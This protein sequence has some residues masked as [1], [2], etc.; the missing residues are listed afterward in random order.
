MTIM[1]R[2]RGKT[3]AHIDCSVIT[4]CFP[5]PHLHPGDLLSRYDRFLGLTLSLGEIFLLFVKA[6]ALRDIKWDRSLSFYCTSTPSIYHT[7]SDMSSHP[8]NLDLDPL[9]NP[10]PFTSSM[11][12]EHYNVV[13]K[14]D[15]SDRVSATTD[16]VGPSLVSEAKIGCTSRAPSDLDVPPV[17][18][19]IPGDAD[20][21]LPVDYAFVW[22]YII[23]HTNAIFTK[24][25]GGLADTIG[26]LVDIS[27]LTAYWEMI[28]SYFALIGD[29]MA[30]LDN[31]KMPG[32][33]TR[34]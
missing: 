30:L 9:I 1:L 24:A 27:S 31:L 4:R 10:K 5:S 18:N 6:L 28:R 20:M 17:E 7:M 2:T 34:V 19:G 26:N 29:R 3:D 14:A 33:V 32:Y 12:N 25:L 21:P 13:Q 8:D 22:A 16:S 15:G 23:A 11:P